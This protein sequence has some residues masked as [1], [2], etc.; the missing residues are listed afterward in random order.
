VIR[1]ALVLVVAA[2]LSGAAGAAT[3]A[4]W[5]TVTV[6][7]SSGGVT[8]VMTIEKRK[9]KYGFYDSRNMHLAV[10]VDGHTIL[11]RSLCSPLRC[12]L[13][14]EQILSLHKVSGGTPDVFL[15]YYTGGAHCCFW[16]FIVT[17]T[18][19]TID[20]D[21]GDPGYRIVSYQGAPQLVSADDRFA[22]E[23]TS[24]A[25]SGL[26][27]QVWAIT[28]DGELNHPDELVNVTQTR[29]DLVKKDA[30]VWWKAY[31][32]ERGKAESDVRGV[33][34]AWCADEYRLGQKSA[35]DAELAKALQKGWIKGVPDWAS[36]AKYIALVHKDLAAWGYP[37]HP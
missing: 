28:P 37:A 9:T 19:K 33:L 32:S 11:D 15:D 10:T 13:G 12:G 23:F 22:Y 34:A 14:T 29:L 18:G 4:P 20:H 17:P 35:C 27:V 6:H 21:W 1:A 5:K 26:P 31:V 24:F 25:G 16:S 2:V 3:P 30:A 36:N 7:K 8:A